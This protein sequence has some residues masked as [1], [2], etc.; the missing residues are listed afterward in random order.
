MSQF[1]QSLVD[2]MDASMWPQNEGASP[3]SVVARGLDTLG[4]VA[5]LHRNGCGVKLELVYS[6]CC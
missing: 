2:Q 5:R 6:W 3:I 4:V 1:I